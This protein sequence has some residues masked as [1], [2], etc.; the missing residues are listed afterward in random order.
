[1]AVLLKGAAH[2]DSVLERARSGSPDMIGAVEAGERVGVSTMT[3]RAAVLRGDIAG[4]WI[5]EGHKVEVCEAS[6]LAW[7]RARRLIVG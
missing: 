2:F 3:I 7:A 6:L 5:G 1:M 4:V